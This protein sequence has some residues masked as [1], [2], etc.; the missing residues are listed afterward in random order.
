MLPAVFIGATIA[1]RGLSSEA[2]AATTNCNGTLAA[3]TYENVNVLAGAACTLDLNAHVTVMHDLIVQA[4][5]SLNDQAAT[6]G[7]DV[8][9]TNPQIISIGY[10]GSV[11]H[12]I[13][14]Q[15][16]T[17]SGDNY[18]CNTRIGHDLS[19]SNG[20][21]SASVLNI[22]PPRCAAPLTVGHDLTVRNNANPVTVSDNSA[23]HDLV[24]QGNTGGTTVNGNHAGHD[25]A[26]IANTG[27]VAAGNGNTAGHNNTCG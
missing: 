22:G 4:T 16:L 20:L 19:V 5:G 18:I 11:G 8:V 17:G 25:A 2:A 23:G 10:G 1:A 26:C 6:V 7:H 21:V 13:V 14:I 27:F 3:G 12:D 9:A 15:G 24:V